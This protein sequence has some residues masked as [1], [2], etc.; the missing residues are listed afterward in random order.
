MSNV[1]ISDVGINI[2]EKAKKDIRVLDETGAYAYEMSQNLSM[3]T[4]TQ[5]Q[6]EEGDKGTFEPRLI[7]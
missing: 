4:E 6:Y 7:K 5:A 3:V 2:A 1:K